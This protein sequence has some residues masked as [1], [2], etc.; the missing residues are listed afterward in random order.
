MMPNRHGSRREVRGR[1]LPWRCEKDGPARDPALRVRRTGGCRC[2]RRGSRARVESRCRG[3]ADGVPR[4]QHPPR[5]GSHASAAG[6]T[7]LPFCRACGN[8]GCRCRALLLGG[9][10]RHIHLR[11]LHRGNGCVLPARDARGPEAS[12]DRAHGHH[13]EP[14]DHRRQRHG[15]ARRRLPLHTAPLLRRVAWRFRT[16]PEARAGSRSRGAR[17]QPRARERGGGARRRV[18]RALEDRSRAPRRRR[19][20]RQC[21]DRASLRRASPPTARPRARTRGAARRR[22]DRAGGAGGNAAACRHPAPAGRGARTRPATE[23][24]ASRPARR[25]SS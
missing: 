20:R 14:S 15:T 21:D 9:E 25:A 6:P 23:P 3:R 7:A 12:S 8:A 1:D 4:R 11:K 24:A 2:D 16:E 22:A 10:A 17:P 5:G 18:G 19:T 13:G